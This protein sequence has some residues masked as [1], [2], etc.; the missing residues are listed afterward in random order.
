MGLN[1]R[2]SLGK[3]PSKNRRTK[4]LRAL[5]SLSSVYIRE[6]RFQEAEEYL[7]KAGEVKPMTAKIQG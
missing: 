7:K 3:M 5:I 6:K 2:A 4:F 1:G